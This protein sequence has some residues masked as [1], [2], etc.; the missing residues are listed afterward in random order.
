MALGAMIGADGGLQATLRG[1]RMVDSSSPPRVVP[2][3]LQGSAALAA[4]RLAFKA[5]LA[6][7][8][9]RLKLDL[10][11]QH[12]LDAGS[13]TASVSSQPLTFAPT[14]LQPRDLS[15]AFGRGLQE[16]GGTIRLG[17]KLSWKP[18]TSVT[19]VNLALK[20]ISGRSPDLVLQQLNGVIAFDRIW[21]LTTPP[22]QQL[23]AALADVGLPL[24][25]ALLDFQLLPG[26]ELAI[27]SAS[28][29]LAGGN[30]VLEPVRIGKGTPELKLKAQGLDLQQL[31]ALASIE[32][33]DGTGSLSGEIPVTLDPAGIRVKGGR[34]A[35][36][37]PG[38]LSYAPGKPP[39]ALQGGGESVSLAL[40]AL[41]DFRYD[42][43]RATLDRET[44]GQVSIG[45]H[46]RGKNPGF[47]NGYPVEL[48]FT[49]SGELDRILRRGLA[50]YR[51][52]DSIR[53]R[54]QTFGE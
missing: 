23:A 34:L 9:G 10:S 40:A 35:A 21:P 41:T 39:A 15:P 50:G 32:G 36:T 37:G 18:N 2:L 3:R 26:P 11:G 14:G 54:L 47:Y 27:A 51:I 6:D 31:L 16:V 30:V 45:M 24:T 22:H 7:D 4:G 17:G 46:V 48:N 52:P 43:L 1:A 44:S 29:R 5:A 12:D 33:L 53:Q 38:R 8:A 20:D 19:L 25:D 42:E 28:L 49:L 13:G